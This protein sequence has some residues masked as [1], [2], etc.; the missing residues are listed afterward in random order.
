MQTLLIFAHTFWE[1]SKVNKALLESAKSL[2]NLTIHNLS[3]TYKDYKID[4]ESEIALLQKADRII[5]QFPLFWFSTPSLLKEWE[6]R[7][8][9]AIFHSDNPKLLEGKTFSIITTALGEESSY[10]GSD[11]Y[12]INALLSPINNA[13]FYLGAKVEEAFCIFSANVDNL[14]LQK[15]LAKLR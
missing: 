12:G 4:V 8:L 7:V 5:F 11:G 13:F 14:P 2:N 10:D 9:S 3:T 6:D 15:Y 1:D